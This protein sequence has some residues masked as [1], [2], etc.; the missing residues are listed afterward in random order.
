[1][2]VWLHSQRSMDFLHARHSE[3]QSG[4]TNPSGPLHTP[5]LAL[6]PPSLHV[7]LLDC[8]HLD[9]YKALVTHKVEYKPFYVYY[10]V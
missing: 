10:H 5:T 8:Q 6:C 4:Y 7:S 3:I 2:L 9:Q 1:M